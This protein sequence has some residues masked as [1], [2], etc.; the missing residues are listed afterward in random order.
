M[1]TPLYITYSAMIASR[2]V[3]QGRMALSLLNV[4]MQKSRTPD[5]TLPDSAPGKDNLEVEKIKY[6]AFAH[7]NI[8][9]NVSKLIIPHIFLICK[10]EMVNNYR[11]SYSMIS[12]HEQRDIY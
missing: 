11:N 3:P 5:F 8:H 6:A 12:V 7:C 9:C 2:L 4:I 10:F 1:I